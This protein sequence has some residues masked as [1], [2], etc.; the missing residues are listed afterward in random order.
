[1]SKELVQIGKR[2]K[3]EI[4]LECNAAT[5]LIYKRVFGKN[6][7]DEF[8]KM[9][10]LPIDEKLELIDSIVFVA[11]KMATQ[12]FRDVL[13]L[14]ADDY[15]EFLTQYEIDDLMDVSLIQTVTRMWSENIEVDAEPRKPS[16]SDS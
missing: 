8:T 14:K 11:N 4:A 15:L 7:F 16:E 5:P 6:L 1:M 13:N 3:K 9:E 2:V 10:S 12:P